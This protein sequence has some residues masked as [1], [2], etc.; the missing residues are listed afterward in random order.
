MLRIF[1]FLSVAVIVSLACSNKKEEF[2]ET[3][4]PLIPTPVD[5]TPSRY[6]YNYIP[7]KVLLGDNSYVEFR[8]GDTNTNIIIT[9]PHGGTLRPSVIPDRTQGETGADLYTADLAIKM[10]DSIKARTGY[11]PHIILNN[12]HRIKLDPNRDSAEAYFTHANAINAYKQY[13]DYIYIARNMVTERLGKGLLI[14]VHGHGHAIDRTEVGYLTTKTQLNGTDEDLN[15]HANKSSIK[16]IHLNS[17][18]SFAELIRG[19]LS[20][21]SLMA[22]Q[23]LAAVPS[24]TDLSPG[25][26]LYFTGGYTTQIHGSRDSGTISAIQLEFPRP[27][28]RDTEEKRATAAGKLATV[29]KQ[30][31]TEHFNF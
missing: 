24:N 28:I 31:L 22:A 30:Y 17:T 8:V 15:T 29:V 14:D 3:A 9:A 27:S 21:G 6:T 16:H 2:F 12:L 26:A 18:Y 23:G 20:F 7:G 4:P 5:T 13:H 19:D 11:K 10:A 1:S 25:D